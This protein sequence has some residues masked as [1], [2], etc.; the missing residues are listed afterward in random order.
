LRSHL[1]NDEIE[2]LLLS[3][4]D[5]G[6]DQQANKKAVQSDAFDHFKGCDSCQMMVRAHREAADTMARLKSSSIGLRGSDCPSES[7]WLDLAAGV[8]IKNSEICLNHAAQCEHCGPLLREAAADLSEE[9]S[10]EEAKRMEQLRSATPEWQREF[11]QR[12]SLTA[13][14][15]GAAPWWKSIFTLPRFALAGGLAGAVALAFWWTFGFSTYKSANRL[16]AQAYTENRLFELRLPEAH[17]SPW[18]ATRGVSR[19]QFPRSVHLLQAE[20]LIARE[21]PRHSGDGGW[22]AANGRA[23]LLEGNYDEAIDNFKNAL[24]VS[25]EIILTQIDLATAYSQRGEAKNQ[26]WDEGQAVELLKSVLK[27]QPDNAV[28]LFNLAIVLERQGLYYESVE[29]WRHYLGL[30]GKGPWSDEART[31]LDADEQQIKGHSKVTPPLDPNMLALAVQKDA[32]AIRRTVNE[33]LEEYQHEAAVRWL[34]CAFSV[35]RPRKDREHCLSALHLAAEL[36]KSEHHDAWLSDLLDQIHSARASKAAGELSEALAANDVGNYAKGTLNARLAAQDFEAVKS[37]AG[38]LRSELELV[39]SSR[40]SHDPSTCLDLGRQLPRELKRRGYA[41]AY[42]QASLELQECFN[43]VGQVGQARSLSGSVLL[44]AER[45][46]YPVLHLRA[47]L[48]AAD[49]DASLGDMKSAWRL[50]HKGL[51]LSWEESVPPMR[52]YSF[53]TELDILADQSGQHYFDSMVLADGV[54]TIENDPD[55]LLRAMAQERLAE[56]YLSVGD[57]AAAEEEFR[58]TMNLFSAAPQSEVTANHWLETRIGVARAKV[59]EHHFDSAVQELQT[60]S[61]DIVSVTD[62]FLLV[63]YWRTLGRAKLELADLPGAGSAFGRA[64]RLTEQALSTL[65]SD[66][67]RIEWD[68]ASSGLYRD[69]IE[70]KLRQHD[71]EGALELWEWYRAAAIRAGSRA[72]TG[73]AIGGPSVSDLVQNENLPEPHEVSQHLKSLTHET[74]VSFAFLDGGLAT[75]AYDN[76]GVYF[77]WVSDKAANIPFL[78]S[79]FSELCA[80]PL[81]DRQTL[82]DLGRKLYDTLLATLATDFVQGRTLIFEPDGPLW[83]IPMQALKDDSGRY[84]TDAFA[85]SE[86]PG[87]YYRGILRPV[88]SFRGDEATFV[89]ASRAGGSVDGV[90]LPELPNV[91]VEARNVANAFHQTVIS[92]GGLSLAALKKEIQGAQLFH[93]AGHALAMPDGPALLISFPAGSSS[94]RV[95][96]ASMI[97][98]MSFHNLRLAVLSGCATEDGTE[99]EGLLDAGSLARA[100]LRG[101]VPEV[102]ASH[103]MVDSAATELFMD[104]FYRAVLADNTV[105]ASVRLAMLRTRSQDHDSHPYYWAAFSAFGWA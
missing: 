8:S 99:G 40:L 76:R 1:N 98:Q 24:V 19:S 71:E 52:I 5:L 64:L 25:P 75:W 62:R 32:T 88:L 42:V 65:D 41:W 97:S 86:F 50:V 100:F 73:V 80:D 69:I 56:A 72:E 39:Y 81:S 22:L 90:V 55:T 105:P 79:R 36:A 37:R 91:L 47:L 102:V 95:L 66:K 46:G 38:Y 68:H 49:V 11:A 51:C 18:K 15:S 12:L 63:D 14:T 89:I 45:T 59:K 77:H 7:V 13:Q 93:F 34:P 23:N 74:V 10:I 61:R 33:R 6:D 48:F 101:G 67:A 70:L 31:H 92:D 4:L 28:A 84:L 82:S 9:L 78:A 17:Y 16:L 87:L 44:A 60:M 21:L 103:W 43:M 29:T 96:T 57:D 2:R 27:Q 3:A 83:A 94:P 35:Q 104:T 85:I 20:T 54:R 53:E 26:P 58:I 30:D